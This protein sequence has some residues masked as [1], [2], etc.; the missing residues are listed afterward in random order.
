MVAILSFFKIIPSLKN[1]FIDTV[2]VVFYI[3]IAAS[4][5][6]YRYIIFLV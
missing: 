5:G 2:A 1:K 3:L 6:A 4:V